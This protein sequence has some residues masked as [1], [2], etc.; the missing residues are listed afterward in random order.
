MMRKSD[1]ESRKYWRVGGYLSP[2]QTKTHLWETPPFSFGR[3]WLDPLAVL[4]L[5][6]L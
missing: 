2:P 5:S 4:D 1:V 3:G 6:S